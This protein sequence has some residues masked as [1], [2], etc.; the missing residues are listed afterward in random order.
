MLPLKALG[1]ENTIEVASE[2]GSSSILIHLYQN[3]F[4]TLSGKQSNRNILVVLEYSIRWRLP[5]CMI[6][7]F[8]YFIIAITMRS[9]AVFH[10][11]GSRSFLRRAKNN[12]NTSAECL[13][14]LASV[15]TPNLIVVVFYLTR[16]CSIYII[17]VYHYLK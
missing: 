12:G 10:I 5:N 8:I 15:L 2:L 11:L 16:A 4:A 7:L 3:S 9:F 14:S 6:M 17:V 1:K 13:A